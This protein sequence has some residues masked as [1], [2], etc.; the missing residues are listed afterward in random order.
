MYKGMLPD[1]NIV[2]VKKSK[3]I[4]KSQIEQFINEVVIL[5]QINHRNIVKLLGCCL[6]TEYPL[7]VYGTLSQHIYGQD[8]ELAISWENRITIACEVAGAIA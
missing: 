5:S 6:E 8:L 3:A 7:L 1:G 2:A 4:D